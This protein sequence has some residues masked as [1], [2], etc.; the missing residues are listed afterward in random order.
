M[1]IRELARLNKWPAYKNM[2]I[3]RAM[4]RAAAVKWWNNGIVK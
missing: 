2:P 3:R 1:T 4:A